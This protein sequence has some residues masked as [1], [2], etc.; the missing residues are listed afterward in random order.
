MC[1]QSHNLRPFTYVKQASTGLIIAAFA[2]ASPATFATTDTVYGG[3]LDTQPDYAYCKPSFFEEWARDDA[4][5]LFF[6]TLKGIVYSGSPL[7][8]AS[9]DHFVKHGVPVY[10]LYGASETGV[11]GMVFPGQ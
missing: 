1:R 3:Y 7:N 10:T 2:P 6:K 8:T 9:G 5:M 4:K 11:M